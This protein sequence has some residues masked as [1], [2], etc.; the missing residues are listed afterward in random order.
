M[1]VYIS[2]FICPKIQ[3]YNDIQPNFFEWISL[4]EIRAENKKLKKKS[5]KFFAPTLFIIL[6]KE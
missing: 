2:K 3:Q 6:L 5:N 1:S 4:Y